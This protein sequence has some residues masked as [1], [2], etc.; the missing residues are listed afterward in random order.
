MSLPIPT[1]PRQSAS[2][3]RMREETVTARRNLYRRACALIEHGYRRPLTLP[4]VAAILAISP[5]HL[6]RV[7]EQ[8][9]SRT[10]SE[11]LRWRRMNAA[12]ELLARPALPIAEVAQRVGYSQGPHFAR[13]FRR[14]HGLSP[15]LYRQAPRQGA[16]GKG[17][18]RPAPPA[19][20]STAS[21]PGRAGR[22]GWLR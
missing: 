7:F 3:H 22:V 6:Q 11:E 12:C 18:G 13:A 10:F 15:S 14:C 16:R 21:P 20:G 4:A 19:G 1:S 5:R 9:G 17:R 2:Q 8:C